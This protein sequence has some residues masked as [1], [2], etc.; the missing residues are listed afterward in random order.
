MDIFASL[1]F[2]LIAFRSGIKAVCF[3]RNR[4]KMT[5]F[6]LY[7]FRVFGSWKSPFCSLFHSIID[8]SSLFSLSYIAR[9]FCIK[10][11]IKVYTVICIYSIW[12]LVYVILKF[13]IHRS[14]DKTIYFLGSLM[15]HKSFK[16]FDNISNCVIIVNYVWNCFV[17][18]NLWCI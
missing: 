6:F 10:F 9:N 8:Y 12:N 11:N 15:T 4:R 1:H 7:I 18:E 2:T 3:S 13:N 17:H 14:V 5:Y 16:L